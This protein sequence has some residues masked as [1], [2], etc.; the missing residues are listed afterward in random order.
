MF[1]ARDR[2]GEVILELPL[3][4]GK[5]SLRGQSLSAAVID[6]AMLASGI[7]EDAKFVHCSM[8]GADFTC[9][10]V[11]RCLFLR[12]D[13]RGARFERA[14]CRNAQFRRCNLGGAIFSRCDL[15]RAY[16]GASGLTNRHRGPTIS[17][18]VCDESTRIAAPWS[19]ELVPDLEDFGQA[20]P[21]SL[22]GDALLTHIL[23][24]RSS[25]LSLMT[26]HPSL[27]SELRVE[28]TNRAGRICCE[29]DSALVLSLVPPTIGVTPFGQGSRSSCRS[30]LL[31]RCARSPAVEI[32]F[33]AEPVVSFARPSPPRT[34]AV[35]HTRSRPR[36][37]PLPESPAI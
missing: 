22:E 30:A 11:K 34:I 10:N 33:C 13:L 14:D 5:V 28:L 37:P 12:C 15:R 32:L 4:D 9:A 2:N 16:L 21:L 1:V 27:A 20:A 36:R 26:G 6:G 35:L 24:L 19:K 23:L 18:A 8:R 7:C 3:V 25:R 17:M 29:R 31:C